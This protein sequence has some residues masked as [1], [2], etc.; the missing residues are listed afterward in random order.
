MVILDTA[1]KAGS[2]AI[3]LSAVREVRE[4]LR[5]LG[6]ASGELAQSGSATVNVFASREW[7]RVVTVL[8]RA[9]DTHSDAKTDVIDAPGAAA[10]AATGIAA[11]AC[12]D[13]EH[14]DGIDHGTFSQFHSHLRRATS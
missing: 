6:H 10:R 9:L 4:L 5:L 11:L 8:L 2:L 12:A 1:E 14:S 7:Q 13:G 3:A